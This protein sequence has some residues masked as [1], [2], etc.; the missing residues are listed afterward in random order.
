MDEDPL[1]R[2]FAWQRRQHT[3]KVTGNSD[4][5]SDDSETETR[6]ETQNKNGSSKIN[7]D[8]ANESDF[9][10]DDDTT[11]LSGQ[12]GS[13]RSVRSETV[14]EHSFSET[15]SSYQRFNPHKKRDESVKLSDD[16]KKFLDDNFN[17]F[18]SSDTIQNMI[19][20]RPQCQ[21]YDALKSRRLDP[22]ISSIVEEQGRSINKSV[23]RS[24]CSIQQKLFPCMGPITQLWKILED[25][26]SEMFSGNNSIASAHDWNK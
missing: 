20:S 2:W 8:V 10:S 13:K 24:L 22:F 7:H 25:L 26:R 18:L 9:D 12:S 15:G 17:L 3:E 4:P 1:K 6:R 11:S 14:S 19:W 5:E 23:D 21:C 16:M